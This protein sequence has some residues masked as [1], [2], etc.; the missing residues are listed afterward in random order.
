MSVLLG[1]R[2][3][4]IQIQSYAEQKHPTARASTM[5]FM[6]VGRINRLNGEEDTTISAAMSSRA[7]QLCP[8]QGPIKY[9][10]HISFRKNSLYSFL[11]S[12]CPIGKLCFLRDIIEIGLKWAM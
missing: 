1:F 5:P 3:R 9:L 8:S 6:L 12:Y 11:P 10:L 7:E 2:Y 4:G